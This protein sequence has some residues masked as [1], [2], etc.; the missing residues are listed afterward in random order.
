M[1]DE[2]TAARC[3]DVV[4]GIIRTGEPDSPVTD[5]EHLAPGCCHKA[6]DFPFFEYVFHTLK[7]LP[8]FDRIDAEIPLEGAAHLLR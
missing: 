8:I 6:D 2:K 4:L 3:H 7:P 1:V 5:A